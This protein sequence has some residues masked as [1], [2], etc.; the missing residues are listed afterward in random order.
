MSETPGNV[1][2]DA[3]ESPEDGREES[4]AGEIARADDSHSAETWQP[5]TSPLLSTL[6]VFENPF[7]AAEAAETPPEPQ[8]PE[9]LHAE[10]ALFQSWS[11]PEI[12]PPERIPHLGH[13][14]LLMAFAVFGL[15]GAALLTR[16]ALEFHLFGVTTINQA[17]SDIHYTLG[18]MVLIYLLTLG[19]CVVVFPLLWHK[20]FLAGL[21]WRGATAL[22]LRYRLFFAASGCFVLALADELL[23]P[24]PTN[25]PIDKLFQT[26]QDAWLL[27]AFGVTL[28]PFFEEIGFRGFLLPAL[29]TAWDW[30]I[31]RSTGR[32]ARP[33]DKDGQP[34]WSLFAM[35]GASVATSVPFAL[36]HAEQ[37]AHALG[38]FLLLICVSLILCWTRLATRSLAASV[39]VHSCYN[40][41]LFS[42]MLLGTGGFRHMERM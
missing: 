39:L 28:A 2:G 12:H 30:A 20:G 38:P 7:L 27:F 14:C 21:Q 31:E 33:L 40:F 24:G 34:Q 23:L 1:T 26:S 32:P 5:D 35:A 8:H 4:A 9:P 10:P 19:A 25:A 42:L 29:A 6:A 15:L 17:A 18:N 36:M 22:R 41:L 16:A 3:E 37:T 11:Q 13:V